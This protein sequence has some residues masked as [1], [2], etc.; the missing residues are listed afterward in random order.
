MCPIDDAFLARLAQAQNPCQEPHETREAV[1]DNAEL[2]YIALFLGLCF[3]C[4]V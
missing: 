3:T 1:P 4:S 2:K